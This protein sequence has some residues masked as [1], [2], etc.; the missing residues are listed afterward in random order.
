MYPTGSGHCSHAINTYHTIGTNGN[1]Y[2]MQLTYILLRTKIQQ[3]LI[4]NT[5]KPR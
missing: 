3:L 4:K 1:I 2:S 5:A